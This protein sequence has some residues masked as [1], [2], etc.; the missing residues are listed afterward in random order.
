MVDWSESKKF[1]PR[2]N[3]DPANDMCLISVWLP[4]ILNIH[5]AF[6]F[7]FSIDCTDLV[8]D[9]TYEGALLYFIVS[10]LCERKRKHVNTV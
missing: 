10:D 1:K 5:A 8:C 9:T 4:F 2:D 6:I 3:G 7:A